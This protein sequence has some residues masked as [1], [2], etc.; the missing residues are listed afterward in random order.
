M[1]KESESEILLIPKQIMGKGG[2]YFFIFFPLCKNEGRIIKF[3]IVEYGNARIYCITART[4]LSV[5]G[6]RV[7]HLFRTVQYFN[8]TLNYGVSVSQ[9]NWLYRIVN[10][11]LTLVQQKDMCWSVTA[12]LL[13][14]KQVNVWKYKDDHTWP[15]NNLSLPVMLLRCWENLIWAKLL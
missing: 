8:N 4:I 7:P 3:Y 9:F 13:K 11:S 2:C 1:Y 14:H 6:D 10:S 5:Q 12:S 15:Q